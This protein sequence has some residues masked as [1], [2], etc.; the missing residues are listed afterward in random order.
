M[1][2]VVSISIYAVFL[3]IGI[4]IGK[5]WGTLNSSL[6][7]EA[8]YPHDLSKFIHD[9]ESECESLK[10][11]NLDRKSFAVD[12]LKDQDVMR[13]LSYDSIKKQFVISVLDKQHRQW[14]D[15]FDSTCSE[16]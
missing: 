14:T 8:S 12:F 16:Q 9:F 6:A 10:L 1:N 7:T 4:F 11:L 3:I 5:F 15:T 2:K 13:I